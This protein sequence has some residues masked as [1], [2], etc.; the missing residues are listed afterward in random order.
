VKMSLRSRRGK[1]RAFVSPVVGALRLA[2]ADNE[3]GP[4]CCSCD[5]WA[6][7]TYALETAVG[8]AEIGG[9]STRVEIPGRVTISAELTTG[10]VMST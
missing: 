6:G 8:I 9:E 1:L 10:C 5:I 2:W 4:A 3:E 7:F